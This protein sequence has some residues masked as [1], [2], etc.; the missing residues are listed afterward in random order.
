MTTDT[1]YMNS[2]IKIFVNNDNL[3]DWEIYQYF[4]VENNCIT[5]RET[6]HSDYRKSIYINDLSLI[7]VKRI[8]RIPGFN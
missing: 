5:E 3:Y 6:G 8:K 4:K 2:F 1:F 7:P